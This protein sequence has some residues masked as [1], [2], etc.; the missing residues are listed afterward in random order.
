MISWDDTQQLFRIGAYALAGWL[1]A[2]GNLDPANIET[3]GGALLGL[4]SVAWWW[5]WNRRRAG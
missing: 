3:L 2:R 5:F 4:A 1:G